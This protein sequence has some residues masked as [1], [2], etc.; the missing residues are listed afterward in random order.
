MALNIAS[1]NL[2]LLETNKRQKEKDLYQQEQENAKAKQ[3]GG[4]IGGI[5][6]LLA[7]GLGAAAVIGTGGIAAAPIAA[8]GSIVGA[9]SVGGG[10]GGAVGKAVAPQTQVDYSSL[11]GPNKGQQEL[12]DMTAIQRRAGLPTASSMQGRTNLPPLSEPTKVMASSLNALA[13]LPEDMQNE[14]GNLLLKGITK[15]FGNDLLQSRMKG[16]MNGLPTSRA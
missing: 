4:D 7:A 11:E 9:A 6:G 10:V 2:G 13:N 8:L 12:S 16:G 1:A 14:Y 15:S 3:E 5:L